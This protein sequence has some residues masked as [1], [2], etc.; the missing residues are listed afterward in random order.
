MGNQQQWPLSR[1]SRGALRV[2][3]VWAHSRLLFNDY[4]A[5][6]SGLLPGA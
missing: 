1:T 5:V 3:P 2:K 6:G 4:V